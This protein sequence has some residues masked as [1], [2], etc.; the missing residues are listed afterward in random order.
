MDLGVAK[1]L[2]SGTIVLAISGELDI[3]TAPA[4]ADA[5]RGVAA[6]GSEPVV[7]DLTAVTFIDSTGLGEI[8]RG[9]NALSERQRALAVACS[10]GTLLRLFTMTGVDELIT[11]RPTRAEAVAAAGQD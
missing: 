1:E 6:S 5:L 10:G 8:V 3:H 4:L 7:V 11:I 9:H 2:D